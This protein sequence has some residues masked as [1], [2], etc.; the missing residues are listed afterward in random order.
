MAVTG[1]V[2]LRERASNDTG[3]KDDG[4]KL[5]ME[6]IPP[7]VVEATAAVLTFGASKYEDRNWERGMKWG[8]VFGALMRHLWSWWR[9]ERADPETGYSH[10]WHA[11]CCIAFLIAYEAR[12][13]GEDDRP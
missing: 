9:R 11:A 10:L 2:A 8:R 4:G 7:E 12:Q 1:E 3:R 5:R 6:L 13:C